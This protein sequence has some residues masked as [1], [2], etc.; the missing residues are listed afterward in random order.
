MWRSN[1][2]IIQ[3]WA[4]VGHNNQGTLSLCYINGKNVYLE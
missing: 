1:V 3:K 2:E 4:I